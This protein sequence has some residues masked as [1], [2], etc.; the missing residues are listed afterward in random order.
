MTM[1]MTVESS[2]DTKSAPTPVPKRSFDVAFLTGN[3]DTCSQEKRTADSDVKPTRMSPLSTS[4]S[5]PPPLKLSKTPESDSQRLDRTGSQDKLHSGHGASAFKK[6]SKAAG[7]ATSTT[8]AATV[9]AAAAAAASLSEIGSEALSLVIPSQNV[10]A[11]CNL[12]FRMTSDLVYHMRSQHRRESDPV[13]QKRQEKLRCPVCGESFR[14]RH[15]LTRHMTSHEDREV[16]AN[17]IKYYFA[18][19]DTLPLSLHLHC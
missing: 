13:R 14:E 19:N 17:L 1:D 9:A 2:R 18:T 15:H 3:A 12:S 11:K 16:E 5:S 7:Q 8:T 4:S 6:V 10:C